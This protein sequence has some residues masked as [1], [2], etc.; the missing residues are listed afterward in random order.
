LLVVLHWILVVDDTWWTDQLVGA[1]IAVDIWC[2]SQGRFL[3][4]IMIGPG[5]ESVVMFAWEA[6]L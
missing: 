2:F 4:V 5:F 6:S 3:G 1:S